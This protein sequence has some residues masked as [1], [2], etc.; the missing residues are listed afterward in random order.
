M[1]MIPNL[2][3]MMCLLAISTILA[4]CQAAAQPNPKDQLPAVT[5]EGRALLK[6]FVEELVRIQPGQ[7]GFPATFTL[8]DDAATQW[9]RPTVVIPMKESFSIAKHETPQN[10][11]EFVMG[12]NPSRWKGERN[13]TETITWNNATSCC[14]RLTA[15]LRQE[16]LIKA[17]DVVRLPSEVEWEYCCRAGTTTKYSFGD[18]AREENEPEPKASLLDP[19]AWHTGNAAGNDP[20]VGVLK[21]N[22]WGLYDMHGYLWEYCQDDWH[23]DYTAHPGNAAPWL[24]EGSR[25]CVLRGGSWKETHEDLRSTSRKAL[26]KTRK[27]DGVGFRCVIVDTTN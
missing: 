13:S 20:A 25:M 3:H 4:G 11:Y 15:L 14:E 12:E 19:Y 5:E 17:T 16:K 24:K 18:K 9:E 21:P 1:P 10:L 26:V 2:L 22:P 6:T 27:E 7:E 23:F 8:G